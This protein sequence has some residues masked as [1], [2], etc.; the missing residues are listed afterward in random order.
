MREWFCLFEFA[1]GFGFG[2]GLVVFWVGAIFDSPRLWIRKCY[3]NIAYI[4]LKN[5]YRFLETISGRKRSQLND[6]KVTLYI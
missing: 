6:I 3:W 1:F 2:F 5:R 4:K